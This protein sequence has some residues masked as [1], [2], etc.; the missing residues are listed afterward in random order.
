MPFSIM[1]A[2]TRVV[3]TA[4]VLMLAATGAGPCRAVEGKQTEEGGTRT[5]KERLGGKA[6]DE[7][8]VDNCKVPPGL[9]GAK[10][11][12]ERC[13]EGADPLAPR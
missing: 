6:S 1:R 4:L 10:P 12:P 9:R 13:A 8:R 7:Q 5:G 2:D 11:R 3:A